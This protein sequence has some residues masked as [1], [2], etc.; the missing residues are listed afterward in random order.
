MKTNVLE[1]LVEKLEK[2]NKAKRDFVLKAQDI[3]LTPENEFIARVGNED[4]FFNA[5][6]LFDMQVAE[7][8]Q[9]LI[10]GK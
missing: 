2:R 4:Y 6:D 10:L 5:S 7:K 8:L 1:R 9:P 3:Y